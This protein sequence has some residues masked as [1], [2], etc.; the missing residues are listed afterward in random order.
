MAQCL[1]FWLV[2][3]ISYL[4]LGISLSAHP[5]QLSQALP[6]NTPGASA[7]CPT[8]APQHKCCHSS[9]M[10]GTGT[11]LWQGH[12]GMATA[13][14]PVCMFCCSPDHQACANLTTEKSDQRA[15]HQRRDCLLSH[16]CGILFHESNST[17]GEELLCLGVLFLPIRLFSLRWP[18]PVMLDTDVC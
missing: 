9:R 2:L 11:Q 1:V 14:V 3:L 15:S 17:E 12:W 13:Q 4:Q 10:H 8:P 7:C 6:S 18:Q 5:A 16:P